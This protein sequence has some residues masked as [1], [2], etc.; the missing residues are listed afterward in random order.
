MENE[1]SASLGCSKCTPTCRRW[2]SRGK[3][4]TSFADCRITI[5]IQLR[6][7]N[8]GTCLGNFERNVFDVAD[9]YIRPFQLI[10]AKKSSPPEFN[11][12]RPYRYIPA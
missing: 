4:T 3:R 7:K 8:V 6:G 12:A 9:V 10:L 11:R 2:L 1:E 5:P